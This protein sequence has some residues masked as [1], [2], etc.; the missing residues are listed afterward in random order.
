MRAVVNVRLAP[1]GLAAIA[2][3][4][5]RFGLSRSEVIRLLLA[6]ALDYRREHPGYR[7]RFPQREGVEV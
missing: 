5:G 7:G 2:D 3:L 1:G 4:E 6:E